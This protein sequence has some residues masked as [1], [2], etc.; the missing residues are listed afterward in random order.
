M[1]PICHLCRLCCL[2]R[3]C[4]LFCL[5]PHRRR[6]AHCPRPFPCCRG[7]RRLHVVVVVTVVVVA[8]VLSLLLS[9]FSSYDHSRQSSLSPL[10]S[11]SSLSYLSHMPSLPS[12]SPLL[13]FFRCACRRRCHIYRYLCPLYF[14]VVYISDA[15]P[16]LSLRFW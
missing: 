12:S 10:S 5:N 11:L 6:R 9:S 14:S 15:A 16:S 2:S 4:L 13:L 8:L 7:G 3:L 1:C